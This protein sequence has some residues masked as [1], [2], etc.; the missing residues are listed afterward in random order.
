MERHNEANRENNRDGHPANFS[1]NWGVEG[2][3]SDASIEATR[4][5]VKRALLATVFLSAGTP[6]LLAGDEFGRTQQGNNNAYCQDNELSWV[7]WQIAESPSGR[8]LIDYVA[9]LIA[10]RRDHPVLRSKVF[11][12][13]TEHPIPDIADIAWF[14]ETGGTI[15]PAAWR[16]SRAKNVDIAA[17]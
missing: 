9:R 17:G 10:L 2:P 13:G 16:R 7:N 14:D 6:M 11:L 3:T 8:S 15:S 12:H 4:A 1:N 5:R